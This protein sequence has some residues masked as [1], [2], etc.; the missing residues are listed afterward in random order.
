M[1]ENNNENNHKS[2]K[3]NAPRE[4]VLGFKNTAQIVTVSSEEFARG[5]EKLEAVSLLPWNTHE[6]ELISRVCSLAFYLQISGGLLTAQ[7]MTALAKVKIDAEG[8]VNGFLRRQ[9]IASATPSTGETSK[10]N[11]V[12]RQKNS[13]ETGSRQFLYIEG[14]IHLLSF[15]RYRLDPQTP[16]VM[17]AGNSLLPSLMGSWVKK[18]N[19][20]YRWLTNINIASATWNGVYQAWLQNLFASAKFSGSK[21]D[22]GGEHIL[23]SDITELAA[24]QL[25]NYEPPFIC[26]PRRLKFRQA[27]LPNFQLLSYFSNSRAMSRNTADVRRDESTDLI[28]IL[29]NETDSSEDDNGVESAASS[30]LYKEVVSDREFTDALMKIHEWLKYLDNNQSILRHEAIALGRDLLLIPELQKSAAADLKLGIEWVVYRMANKRDDKSM[31]RRLST[32]TTNMRRLVM[33]LSA[34]RGTRFAE[35]TT[36]DFA[37]FLESYQTSTARAQKSTVKLFDLWLGNEK[38]GPVS[39][40]NWKSGKLFIRED[41]SFYQLMIEKDFYRLLAS[42]DE[43]P[44]SADERKQLRVALLLLRRCG[45]RCG[46]AVALKTINLYGLIEELRLKVRSSKSQA[47][48]RTLP[49]DWLFDEDELIELTEFFELRQSQNC[50]FLFYDGKEMPL[51]AAKLGNLTQK[52]L[53]FAGIEDQTAHSLRHSFANDMLSTFWLYLTIHLAGNQEMP[54][55]HTFGW[56]R[57]ALQNDF[58]SGHIAPETVILFDDIRRLLGHAHDKVTLMRYIHIIDLMTA[59]AIRI[60]ET[61]SSKKSKLLGISAA[62]RLVG[63]SK[64]TV[65]KQFVNKIIDS[66]DSDEGMISIL[67]IE[68]WLKMRLEKLARKTN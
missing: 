24:R 45:L 65:R 10:A 42:L 26:Y 29:E 8:A 63:V 54:T 11:A 41:S 59:D 51:T 19:E 38:S 58:S 33:F 57:T 1:S 17:D 6:E 37:E 14:R 53:S 7:P 12:K 39:K 4:R 44:F 67:D 47:G 46:E 18:A 28:D 43:S 35:I 22:E 31:Y 55:A 68:S 25:Y 48:R 32:T 30:F 2:A 13:A 40:I 36:D 9:P 16:F 27:F 50:E 60:S 34:I 5:L 21:T 66:V 62:A 23:L 20:N 64:G 52:A 49:L 61:I 56:A 3:E 15:V